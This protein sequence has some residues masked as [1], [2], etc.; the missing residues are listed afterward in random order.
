MGITMISSACGG[1]SGAPATSDDPGR[2]IVSDANIVIAASP[3]NTWLPI[4]VAVDKGYF[5]EAGLPNAT[6][7]QI[8]SA[9]DTANALAAN[10][11]QFAGLAFERAALA[12]INGKPTQCVVAI[13]DTPPVAVVV[14]SKLDVKPG[15]WGALRGKTLGVATGGWSEIAPKYLLKKNGVDLKDVKFTNTPNPAT[16]LAALKSGQVDGFGG[17]EPAQRQAVIEGFGKM[18]FDLMTK[19]A[20]AKFWP[21]PFQATCLQAQASYSKANPQIVAAVVKVI[22]RTLKELEAR[23]QD[24]IDYAAKASPTTDRAVTEASVKAL[25]ATWSTDGSISEAAVA[26]VQS[27]LVEF[28]VLPRAL[29]YAEVVFTGK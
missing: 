6:F 18:F 13:G 26:N 2:G 16:M 20:A 15:D 3:S 5:K 7:T 11:V 25:I 27:V 4:R 23:P 29:P 8:D 22:Q 10:A 9:A 17:T 28:G 24:A 21:A 1:S 14:S 12:T 19:E